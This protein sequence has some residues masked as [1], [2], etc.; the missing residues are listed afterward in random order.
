MVPCRDERHLPTSRVHAATL[1]DR[2]RPQ[3]IALKQCSRRSAS[4]FPSTP[5]ACRPT[6]APSLSRGSR[7][8][9][10]GAMPRRHEQSAGQSESRQARRSAHR[11]KHGA[12]CCEC[13][14]ASGPLATPCSSPVDDTHGSLVAKKLH[15]VSGP[16][17]IRKEISYNAMSS[18]IAEQ[19]S[20]SRLAVGAEIKAFRH[21]ATLRSATNLSGVLSDSFFAET[22]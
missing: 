17:T 6:P 9:H 14:P 10:V 8:R 15:A 19:R 3:Q 16:A 22:M 11:A 2:Y 13:Q 4:S 18:T 21:M 1:W 5:F 12:P 7:L 20:S